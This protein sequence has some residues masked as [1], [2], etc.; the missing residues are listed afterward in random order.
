MK[1]SI[2]KKYIHISLSLIILLSTVLLGS[3]KTK[4]DYASIIDPDAYYKETRLTDQEKNVYQFCRIENYYTSGE[5]KIFRVVAEKAYVEELNLLI[6]IEGSTIVKI[7]GIEVKESEKYGMKCFSGNYL[8]QFIGLDLSQIEIVRG[9]DTPY[10]TGEIIYVSHATITS[11][12]I[13]AA[14]NAV[15]TFLK[16]Q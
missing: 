8:N 2:V 14:V 12:A 13:I 9:K 7:Q 5:K 6:L 1:K 15:A 11:K 3:C 16:S 4:I 10:D